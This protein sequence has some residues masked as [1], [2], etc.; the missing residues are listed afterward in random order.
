MEGTSLNLHGEIIDGV[1]DDRTENQDGTEDDTD[2][3]NV[4]EVRLLSCRQ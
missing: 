4:G 3:D 1:D 2:D